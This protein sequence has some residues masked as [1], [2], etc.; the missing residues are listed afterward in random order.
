MFGESNVNRPP[1][2]QSIPEDEIFATVPFLAKIIPVPIKKANSVSAS[3]LPPP[4]SLSVSSEVTKSDVPSQLPPS[5][6]IKKAA[7]TVTPSN[8]TNSH[9]H[10]VPVKPKKANDKD[11]SSSLPVSPKK[12]PLHLDCSGSDEVNSD[13]DTGMTA[14]LY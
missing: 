1:L 2:P 7:S 8:T 9:V 10:K 13:S 12:K 14:R 11:S 6:P 3:K 4:S 5:F